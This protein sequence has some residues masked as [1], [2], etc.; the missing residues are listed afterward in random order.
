M[1]LACK[2]VIRERDTWKLKGVGEEGGGVRVVGVGVTRHPLN[3][4]DHAPSLPRPFAPTIL[5][6]VTTR[7]S[8]YVT[9]DHNQQQH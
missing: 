1:K 9:P 3:T 8:W 7:Y 4:L 5:C 2:R 6:D